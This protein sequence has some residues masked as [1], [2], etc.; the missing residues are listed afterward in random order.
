MIYYSHNKPT[1]RPTD[2]GLLRISVRE[3]AVRER[4]L[5][6]TTTLHYHRQRPQPRHSSIWHRESSH[7][8]VYLSQAKCDVCISEFR[9]AD[10]LG[11]MFDEVPGSLPQLLL[12]VFPS[13]TFPQFL[14]GRCLKNRQQLHEL[15]IFVIWV[16]RSGISAPEL[17][18]E[19]E[20]FHFTLNE[21]RGFLGLHSKY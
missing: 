5:A 15:F 10:I 17:C 6:K 4:L 14:T 12:Q 11:R 3:P 20:D 8:R 13:S 9:A 21:I 1:W 7:H 16:M 2:H 19:Y 18:R